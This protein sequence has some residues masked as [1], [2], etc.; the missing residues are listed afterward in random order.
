MQVGE[1]RAHALPSGA[2]QQ[3]LHRDSTGGA[4]DFMGSV[5]QHDGHTTPHKSSNASSSSSS[6]SE[7]LRPLH[8]SP[9]LPGEAGGG[10]VGG[11]SSRVA[12]A[13]ALLDPGGGAEGSHHVVMSSGALLHHLGAA[14][15]Q[16]TSTE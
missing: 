12:K 6:H 14:S 10:H 1:A 13:G 8:V 16:R 3:Q 5:M 2:P 9:K 7:Q 11:M 4:S 15:H